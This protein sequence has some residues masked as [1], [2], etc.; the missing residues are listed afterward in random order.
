MDNIKHKPQRERDSE[1]TWS[2]LLL[3]NLELEIQSR[4]HSLFLMYT[5]ALKNNKNEVK[6][7]TLYKVS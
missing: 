6:G 3:I 4:I 2:S 5:Q 7:I 1:V